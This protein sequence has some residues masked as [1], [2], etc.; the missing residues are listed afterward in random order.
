MDK[1]FLYWKELHESEKLE[2]FSHDRVG[3]LWLKTKSIIRKDLLKEFLVDNSIDLKA[4][5]LADQFIELFNR[6]ASDPVKSGK[7]LDSFI[8][9]KNKQQLAV[10]DEKKLVSEL[11]KLKWFDWGG[12][13]I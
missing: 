3:L 12:V 11:Y 5:K 4:T 8:E 6:L 10:L 1:T 9:A 7:I 13:I 2:Q